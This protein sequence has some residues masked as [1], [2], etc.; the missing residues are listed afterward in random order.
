MWLV[1]T[2]A[3]VTMLWQDA[4]DT[5]RFSVARYTLH[6]G[7]VVALLWY[8]IRTGPSV[9]QLPDL[10]PLLLP[11]LRIGKLIPV[12]VI[13]LLLAAEFSDQGILL[14]LLMLA[15]IWILVVWRREIGLLTIL[16]GLAVTVIAYLGGLPFLNNGSVGEITFYGLLMS[17]PPMYIAGGLLFNRTGLGGIQLQARRYVKALQSFLWGCLLFVPLGLINAAD[18]STAVDIT[19]VTEWW[20]PFSLTWFS[21]IAEETWFRLLLVGLCYF[22]LRPAFPR[23]PVVPIVIAVLFSAIRHGLGHG[24][25]FLERVL[26]TGLLYSLPMAVVFARRDWEHAVGAHYMIDMIP[27]LMVFLEA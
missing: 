13:A 21:A 2:V 18:G 11:K 6:A 25:T 15:T 14:P 3:I 10:S 12:I 22:S 23:R 19:W 7:Y 17:V 9:K 27:S 5:N 8:L 20:M 4:R 1:T 16:L 26:V 24:G